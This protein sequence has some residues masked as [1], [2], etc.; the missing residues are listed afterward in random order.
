MRLAEKV[1]EQLKQDLTS[2]PQAGAIPV[3]ATTV[4][5]AINELIRLLA[6]GDKQSED[7]ILYPPLA[8][9]RVGLEAGASVDQRAVELRGWREAIRSLSPQ[10]ILDSMKG[11]GK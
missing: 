7:E 9:I 1:I 11:V 5:T 10:S 3:A 2:H 8:L 4:Q 6:A